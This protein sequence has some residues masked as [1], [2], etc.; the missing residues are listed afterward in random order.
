MDKEIFVKK[1]DWRY[2]YFNFRFQKAW[3]FRENGAFKEKYWKGQK[4]GFNNFNKNV[5]EWFAKLYKCKMTIKDGR[6]KICIKMYKLHNEFLS[7]IENC[8]I[9]DAENC[10]NAY[11]I[12]GWRLFAF[13]ISILKM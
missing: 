8:K 3:F 12:L 4:C 5:N 11:D 2:Q 10:D 6:E 7:G 13:F 1:Y 9:L